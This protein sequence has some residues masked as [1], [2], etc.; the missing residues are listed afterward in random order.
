LLERVEAGVMPQGATVVLTVTGHGLKDPSWALKD[1]HG[2][3]IQPTKVP[4][5][6]AHIADVLGL[7]GASA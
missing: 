1:Q 2:D 7:G 4:I 3:D 5:D 6:S